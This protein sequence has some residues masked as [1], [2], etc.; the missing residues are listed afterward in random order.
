[1][2][3][4]NIFYTIIQKIGKNQV[5]ILYKCKKIYETLRKSVAFIII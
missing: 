5:K 1:M 4:S 3:I 2:N